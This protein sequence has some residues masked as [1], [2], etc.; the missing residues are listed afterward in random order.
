LS[1]KKTGNSKEAQGNNYK[2][3]KRWESNRLAKLERHL[4]SFPNDEVAKRAVS[5]I[6]YRRKNPTTPFWSHTMIKMAM[7]FKK[8][9]GAFDKDV[10]STNEKLSIAATLASGPYSK[11]KTQP[12]VLE[13]TMFSIGERARYV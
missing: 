7:L 3:T 9:K 2:T 13:K 6:V 4:K 5:N 11:I 12:N 10:F 8:F 1:N